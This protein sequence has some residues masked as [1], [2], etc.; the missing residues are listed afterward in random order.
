MKEIIEADESYFGAKRV[1]VMRGRGA[2]V[3][4]KVFDLLKLEG[5][6]YTEIVILF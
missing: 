3:K 6:V 2:R 1:K 5:K 4:I